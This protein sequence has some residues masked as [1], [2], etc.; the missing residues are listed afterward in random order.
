MVRKEKDGRLEYTYIWEQVF[1][2]GKTLTVEHHYDSHPGGSVAFEPDAGLI[3]HYCIEPDVLAGIQ[4]M[5][6]ALPYEVNY[7]LHTGANWK[8]SIGKFRLVVDKLNKHALVSFCGHGI[9]KI[10]ATRFEMLK[11]DFKPQQDLT[12]LFVKPAETDPW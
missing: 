7:I 5:Q 12:I 10:A 4:K 1:S 6:G 8:G 2:A 11:T 9:R 3:K